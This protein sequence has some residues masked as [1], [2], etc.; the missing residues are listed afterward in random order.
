[1]RILFSGYHNPLFVALTEYTERAL[2]ALGHELSIFDHR[3]FVLP[4]RVHDWSPLAYRLDLAWLNRR[5]IQQ[6][7]RF[8]PDVVMV[9]QGA[10]LHSR[11]IDTV[12]RKLGV[13]VVN[14]F[15]DY[16]MQYDISVQIAPHYDLFFWGD[17]YPL[18]KHRK[19]GY[20]H[21]QWLPFACDPEI[22]HP[23][24]L[25][26][27]E[28]SQYGCEIC[29][30]GSLYPGRAKLLEQLTDFNL[31]IWGPGWERLPPQSALSD[32]WRGGS[33]P[34]ET[35]VKIFNASDIVLNIDGYG[36]TLDEAGHMANTRVFEAP[37]CGAFQ[38]V[39][40]KHD[41]TTLFTSGRELVC[42]DFTKPEQLRELVT[43]YLRHPD[44]REAIARQ[45][46]EC[47]TK[48]HTYQHRMAALLSAVADKS[49]A[50]R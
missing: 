34:P 9:N 26:A 17:T 47:M 25:T 14:W 43:Y 11:T 29:F 15:Q 8:K 3:Q 19:L 31:A 45:G 33:V 49:E 12:R 50:A 40:E 30:V 1:M 7:L 38:L 10:N 20:T 21:E 48:M 46:M 32:C 24:E 35:W 36:E 4:G 6:A 22:H 41:I 16:P 2:R 5:F 23:V 13:P 39:D 42:Y 28:R 27:A 37:A 18:E 44:E